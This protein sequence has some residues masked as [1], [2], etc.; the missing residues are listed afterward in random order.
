M[1]STE[2]AVVAADDQFTLDARNSGVMTF[3]VSNPGTV[4]DTVVFEILPGD[5]TQRAW[6]T[7]E[8]PQRDVGPQ[9]S[10]AFQ[11]KLAVP[12]GTAARRYDM[13]GLAYSADTA[14]EESSRTSG[15]VSY[16]VVTTEKPKKTPWPFIIAAVVLVVVVAGVVTFLLTRGGDEVQ[17]PSNPVAGKTN[18]MTGD[19]KADITLTGVSGWGTIPMA[20]SQGNGRFTIKNEEIAEFPQLAAAPGAQAAQGD[21]NGD[22]KV[23]IALAGA[24]GWGGVPVA[25][26]K[27]DGTFSLTNKT[28]PDIPGWAATPGA[29]LLAGDFDGDGR[30]DLLFTGGAGW[31]T[32][33]VAFSKGDGS[34]RTT[35]APIADV[36]GWAATAGTK[37]LVG[38]VDGDGKDDLVIAGGTGWASV[39]VAFSKGDGTF[40]VTNLPAGDIAIWAAVPGTKM[41]AGDVDGDGKAD[42]VIAGGAGWHTVPV[43][44][45]AG[46]GTFRASNVGVPSI[47]IWATTPG[48]RIVGGDFNGDGKDDFALTGGAGWGSIPVAIS[49][50][51]G[52]FD[53]KNEV[54][55]QFAGWAQTAQVK[56]V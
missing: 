23:D 21:F 28:S 46:N 55:D 38:D 6:F 49:N 5:G 19:G 10:V 15:R 47:P 32:L 8:E 18:D 3:T 30:D 1:M 9:E 2:W 44:F 29:R 17:Q 52:G 50:G 11:V 31:P 27:G 56:I 14:P 35:N 53:V 34:F 43:A 12:A 13:T 39:P 40:R 16:E 45:S 24:P 42:L 54:V 22:G 41:A 25:F 4:P 7:V 37:A 26:S 48:V 51:S 36:N 33:P 20:I